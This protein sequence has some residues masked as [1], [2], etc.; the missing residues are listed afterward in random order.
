MREIHGDK[1]PSK[2]ETRIVEATLIGVLDEI[3]NIDND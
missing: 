2:K 1:Q 3:N